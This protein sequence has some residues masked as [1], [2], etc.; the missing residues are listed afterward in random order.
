MQNSQDV[1]P[2]VL[3]MDQYLLLN[4]LQHARKMMLVRVRQEERCHIL[5]HITREGAQIEIGHPFGQC[6]LNLS[7]FLGQEAQ[8]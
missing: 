4:P 2:R 8:C 1:I 7:E 3:Q 6:C 5:I